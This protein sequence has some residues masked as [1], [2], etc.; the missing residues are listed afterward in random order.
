MKIIVAP[1]SFK[2]SL[3]AEGVARAMQ[4]GILAVEPNIE[5]IKY[6]MADGGEGFIETILSNVKGKRVNITVH[7][8]N[9]NPQQAN[10]ALINNG[11]TAIIE[12]AQAIGLFQ[13]AQHEQNPLY[14]TSYGVGEM[15]T[16]A[17]NYGCRK[18]ILGL[19]GS[20]TNDGGIGML[21]ALGVKA[22]NKEGKVLNP[23]LMMLKEVASLDIKQLDSRLNNTEIL[24]AS[25]VNNPFIGTNGATAVF[26]PQKGLKSNEILMVDKEMNKLADLYERNTGIAIH[27]IPSAGAAGGIGGA[28]IGFFK[29]KVQSGIQLMI[30]MTDFEQHL[31]EAQLLITGEGK[32]DSQTIFGKVP[33]GISEIGKKYNIPVIIISGSIEDNLTELHDIGVTAVFSIVPKPMLLTECMKKS[34]ILIAHTTEQVVRLFIAIIKNQADFSIPSRGSYRLNSDIIH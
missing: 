21:Q 22:L 24:L 8:A 2:G 5:V 1:D 27:N 17:L 25:D 26:G 9:F 3:S 10:L 18:I 30:Q 32:T 12:V 34:H 31:Q 29:A 7:N 14:A 33:V 16:T 6:P 11:K 28:C 15:I 13:I 4:K 23:Y 19:G 20:A